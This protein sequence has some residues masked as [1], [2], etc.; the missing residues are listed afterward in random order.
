MKRLLTI[1]SLIFININTTKAA[2]YIWPIDESNANETKIEYGYGK[3]TYDSHSYDKT[4][5][6]APYEEEYSNYENHYGV[7][8]IGIKG[9]TYDVVSVVDGT[10]LTTSLDQ[11]YRPGLNFP[12]RNKR[13][14][15]FDG[16]GYGNYVVIREDQ[17]GICFLYGHLKANTIILKNNDKVKKGQKIGTMGS[18]GDSGHMHLHFEVRPSANDVIPN[19][20]SGGHKNLVITTLYGLETKNPVDYIGSEPPRKQIEEPIETPEEN[21]EKN[22][23]TPAKIEKITYEERQ[24]YGKI[25]IEFDKEVRF[26]ENPTLNVKIGNETKQ[27]NYIGSQDYKTHTFTI[28]Y[29]QFDVITEGEIKISLAGGKIVD[30]T[31]N[32]TEANYN[33]IDKVI[34]ILKPY[35]ITN[36][37]KTISPYGLGD[38]DNDGTIDSADASQ[39]L[40]LLKKIQQNQELT[41]TEK[42]KLSK[43]DVNRDRVVDKTDAEIVMEY[44]VEGINE[45]TTTKQQEIQILDLNNDNTISNIDYYILIENINSNNTLY[46]LNKDKKINQDDITYFKYILKKYGSR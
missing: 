36:V 4:Y 22:N 25:D 46:D 35:K 15:S 32:K 40:A 14:S 19:Y 26:L 41:Q 21:I 44:Y 33:I 16:G 37:V 31:D 12:D 9:H 45:P 43:A 24:T 8:I 34:G 18:S 1:L 13:Q 29:N 10:V 30:K 27:A 42:Q 2:N 17:T 7:D 11:L 20:N 5:N 38:I 23:T 6:Y 28:G 3:R 39:I